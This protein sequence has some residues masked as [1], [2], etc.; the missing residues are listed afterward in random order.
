MLSLFTAL[1]LSF[2][3]IPKRCITDAFYLSFTQSS[4]WEWIWWFYLLLF[5]AYLSFKNWR[6]EDQKKKKKLRNN[7]WCKTESN[8]HLYMYAQWPI[9]IHINILENYRS[10]KREFRTVK[11]HNGHFVEPTSIKLV[12]IYLETFLTWMDS[13]AV[14][15]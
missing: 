14:D 4:Q 6:M 12:F 9:L 7:D 8:T 13:G 15:N 1:L 10:S 11:G 3:L 5:I 2:S